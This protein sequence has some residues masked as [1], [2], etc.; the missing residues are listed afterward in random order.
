MWWHSTLGG[1]CVVRVPALVS[2]TGNCNCTETGAQLYHQSA[3][4]A[5]L[6]IAELGATEAFAARMS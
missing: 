3:A 5:V 1:N 6:A 4:A 2:G